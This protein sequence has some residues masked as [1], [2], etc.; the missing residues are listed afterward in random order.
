MESRVGRDRDRASDDRHLMERLG[1]GD[2]AAFDSLIQK[3][4]EPLVTFARG[5]VNSEDQAEDLV[6]ETFLR[7]WQGRSR[8]VPNGTVRAY[9]FTITRNLCLN[10]EERRRVRTD[11]A[12]REGRV[13]RA[14]PSPH[15]EFMGREALRVMNEAV[16]ELP[17]RRREV[18]RLVC[19]GGLSYREV[20]QVMGVAIPTVAN[21]MSAA[22]SHLRSALRPI[23]DHRP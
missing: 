19:L 20:S 16:R 4:W 3:Y 22:L 18:F 7:V 23:T 11:W 14:S 12:M 9:L 5:F 10:D 8:W 2:E 15:A 13:A 21:Q 17:D 6:Q 1:R